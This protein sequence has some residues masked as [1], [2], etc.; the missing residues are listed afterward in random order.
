MKK[1]FT[2]TLTALLLLVPAVLILLTFSGCRET[3]PEGTPDGSVAVSKS[4]ST[5]DPTHTAE[6]TNSQ[7]NQNSHESV[8]LA[9]SKLVGCRV[10]SESSENLKQFL[11]EGASKIKVEQE[12]RGSSVFHVTTSGHRTTI[13]LSDGIPEPE[14]F[15]GFTSNQSGYVMIF[16]TDGCSIS[17][18]N[19]IELAC[20]LR[21]ADGGV[22]WSK[23]EYKDFRVSNSREYISAACFFTENVGFFTARYTDT[24]HFG[25]RTYWTTDGGETWFRM[26]RL[27]MPDLFLPVGIKEDFSS[28]ISDVTLLG[29]V[30]TITV[31]ICY[32]FSFV[33]EGETMEKLYIQYTTENLTDW[34]LVR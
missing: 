26:P 25:P 3:A 21:T 15:C 17:R 22:T 19:D 31:R 16:R 4:G 1:R 2:Q 34:T 13:S 11:Y 20:I 12:D 9:Y 33:F 28:E 18:M 7:S 14:I 29:G 23:T 5:S 24:D 8:M 32:G 27:E 30:Y 10:T 6:E